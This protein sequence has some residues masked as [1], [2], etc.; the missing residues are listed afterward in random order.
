MKLELLD[1]RRAFFHADARSLVYV[2]L[3]DEDSVP[4]MCGKLL[5]SMYGTRDAQQNWEFA[6]R[7]ILLIL[8]F[9]C[10]KASPCAYYHEE[11]NV[12]MVIH[13]DDIAVLGYDNDLDWVRSQIQK[14]CRNARNILDR[15]QNEC[16]MLWRRLIRRAWGLAWQ[17]L[18]SMF[19]PLEISTSTPQHVHSV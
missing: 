15:V 18:F 3:P 17:T 7:Q 12:R 6:L 4:G 14:R 5:K 11:R 13:G 9:T 2:K 1:V 8:G 10:S 19:I 16:Q